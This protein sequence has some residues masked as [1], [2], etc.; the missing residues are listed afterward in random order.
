MNL[1]NLGER[2]VAVPSLSAAL[3]PSVCHIIS[4]TRCV[5]TIGRRAFDRGS[6]ESSIP[7]P[8]GGVNALRCHVSLT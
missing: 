6:V 5:S 2:A 3:H 4:Q 7:L 8:L 1:K